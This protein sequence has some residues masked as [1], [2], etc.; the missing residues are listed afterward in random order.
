[1]LSLMHKEGALKDLIEPW[2]HIQGFVGAHGDGPH[3]AGVTVVGGAPLHGQGAGPQGGP[4]PR[5][6]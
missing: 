1:M 4:P 2:M 5:W 3:A 6:G